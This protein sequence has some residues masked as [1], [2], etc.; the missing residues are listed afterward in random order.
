MS[1]S[2]TASAAA[3]PRMP[4]EPFTAR[5]VLVL[6][7]ALI[8]AQLI[9][10]S[11]VL[12]SGNFYWDDLILI[13]RGTT[14][15]LLSA[16]LL[17]YDH[18]GHFMPAAFFLAGVATKL[19][20]LQWW[21]PAVT[22]LVMQAAAS[23]AVLRLLRKVL[24]NNPMLL[25][26][27]IFYLFSPLTLPSFTWWAA[28]L[29]S[30]PL[31]FGLAW[32]A[33]DAIGLVRTGR[34]RYTVS[35]AII[36]GISLL[37]F[38]K[39]LLIPLV[40]FGVVALMFGSRKAWNSA[41]ALWVSCGLIVAAWAVVYLTVVRTG[42]AF[43]G[44]RTTV[45]LI[46]HGLS[47]GL[48]PTL[49]GG[50]W[51]WERWPPAGPWA[52]PPLVLVIAGW[53]LIV[54]AVVF[55]IRRHIAA[56][57]LVAGYV[58]ASIAVMV[59][60]RSGPET[61]NELAQTLRYVADSAVVIAAS[62]ALILRQ[63]LILRH[64]PKRRSLWFLAAAAFVVSSLVSTATFVDK[65]R[66]D[67]APDYLAATRQ[68]LADNRDVPLLDQ[69]ISTWV[70]T[71]MAYP[72]NSM[73]R[74]FGA[75]EDRPDFASS[76]TDL[77]YLD[78]SGHLVPAVVLPSRSI[79]GGPEA[80]CGYRVGERT[81]IPLDGALPDWDWTVQLNYFSGEGGNLELELDTGQAVTV[82]LKS[83][84]NTTYVR[85]TGSGSALTASAGTS[86]VCV[87]EGPVGVVMLANE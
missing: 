70:L 51:A 8:A 12:A 59:M 58:A 29:N 26:P 79:V 16:D 34:R 7:A 39:S 60:S 48:L 27:L 83:G 76:T 35:G 67:P 62:W 63:A 49:L 78:E 14:F 15:P 54:A 56:L 42:L 47:L 36:T 50:P 55:S 33:G 81:R 82:P 52:A 44:F 53:L 20:P 84:L 1:T 41:S 72:E 71:P 28:A 22:S 46:H 19:A 11:V 13:G 86:D 30:L 68:S 75:L 74:I 61:A 57:A 24:G 2:T 18:D 66:D 87:G 69:P 10:R 31:Q 17:L 45:E 80:G 9:V 38:E 4:T 32:V 3:T 6:A 5:R 77:R 65:W 25:L 23:Y 85:L 37:F 64:Q 73:A 43:H 40:A 21:L